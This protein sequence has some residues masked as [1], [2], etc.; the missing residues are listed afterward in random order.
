[1]YS[2]SLVPAG[3]VLIPRA[4]PSLR[5]LRSQVEL[6]FK[7]RPIPPSERSSGN[8]RTIASP[9][10]FPAGAAAAAVVVMHASDIATASRD[11]ADCGILRQGTRSIIDETGT[12]LMAEVLQS[13]YILGV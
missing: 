1:M 2:R 7:K 3:N 4:M 8:F 9:E 13:K 6:S 11:I 12:A 5:T 10:V